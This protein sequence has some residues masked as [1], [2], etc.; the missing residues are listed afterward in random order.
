MM[1]TNRLVALLTPVFSAAA[2]IGTAFVRKHFPG[3]PVPSGAELTGLEITAATAGAASALKWL[4]GHQK[5]EERADWVDHSAQAVAA[6]AEKADPAYTQEVEKYVQGEIAALEH[7]LTSTS[8]VSDAEE[9]ASQ[10]PAPPV[11]TTKGAGA[12]QQVPAP[13]A[14][15]GS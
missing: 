5:W 13:T 2:A 4:H 9:L 6:R 8:I 14:P 10:P 11:R 12:V 15:R 7:R 1:P 3:L